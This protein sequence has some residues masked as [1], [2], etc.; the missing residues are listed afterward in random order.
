[1]DAITLNLE[2][3]A[4]FILDKHLPCDIDLVSKD[5]KQHLGRLFLQL[6]KDFSVHVSK[7]SSLNDPVSNNASNPKKR[8]SNQTPISKHSPAKFAKSNVP[9]NFYNSQNVTNVLGDS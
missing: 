3:F 4:D 8:S 2:L 1:M 9:P 5:E 7:P 6:E